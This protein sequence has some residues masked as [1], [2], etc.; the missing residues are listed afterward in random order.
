MRVMRAF[1]A[2]F[3][4]LLYHPFAR[5]YDLVAAAVSLGRWQDWV[6]QVRPYLGGRVLE[7]GFGPGHLQAA[8]EQD[9]L[10]IY[11]LD[12]SRQMGRQAR[13]RLRN[14]GCPVRLS[15]G[16][17][18]HLPFPQDTFDRVA[19]TFPSEYIFEPQ[20][21]NEVRR[22]L[23]PGGRLVLLP[24]AWI[25]G[26]R[27]LERLLASLFRVTGQAGKLDVVLPGLVQRIAAYGF[28]VRHELVQAQGSRLLVLIGEKGKG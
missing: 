23:K 26:R 19:C 27:P 15:R 14:K 10:E 12:E 1:L 13:R 16:L 2:I 18:Q 20:T 6:L 8:L 9:G 3:F 22:V 11:G 17:A 28:T 7:L 5:S 24:S 25:T 21:L 4:Q